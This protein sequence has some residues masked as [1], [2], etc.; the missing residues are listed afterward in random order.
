MG[1]ATSVFIAFLL[2]T[3]TA[4]ASDTQGTKKKGTVN[5]QLYEQE[6]EKSVSGKVKVVRIVQ[7]ETEVFIENP[8]G[9]SGPYVLP[10]NIKN[11]A[12]LLKILQ[13][14]QKPGGPSVLIGID[15]HQIINSVEEA[16]KPAMSPS[17][18]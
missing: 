13:K 12:G 4:L 1:H 15:D 9:G 10:A 5:T 16:E 14:S 11:R 8:K 2:L 6:G 17:E 18:L 3:S 7:E